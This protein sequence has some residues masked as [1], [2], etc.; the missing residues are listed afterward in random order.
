[1]GETRCLHVGFSLTITH[2]VQGTPWVTHG[3]VCLDVAPSKIQLQGGFSKS[4]ISRNLSDLPIPLLIF[5]FQFFPA[6]FASGFDRKGSLSQGR[7]M[8]NSE[9]LIIVCLDNDGITLSND[10]NADAFEQTVYNSLCLSDRDVID[11]STKGS[12][13]TDGSS[14]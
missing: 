5:L 1:M 2:S 9:N 10:P 11:V 7:A 8:Q 6:D 3:R 14:I 12:A 13:P 4:K